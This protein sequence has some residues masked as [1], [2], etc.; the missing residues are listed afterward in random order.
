MPYFKVTINDEEHEIE[1]SIDQV[2]DEV[3]IDDVVRY[4]DHDTILK[5]MGLDPNF[6]LESRSDVTEMVSDDP[7]YFDLSLSPDFRYWNEQNI[8][9]RTVSLIESS[10]F[11][12]SEFDDFLKSQ[13]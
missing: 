3:D 1:L 5:T 11:E 2:L 8:Y 13:E 9:E 6:C 4:H 10:R 12:Y 7:D